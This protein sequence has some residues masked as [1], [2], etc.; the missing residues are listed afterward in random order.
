MAFVLLNPLLAVLL[1]LCIWTV[2]TRKSIFKSTCSS[3]TWLKSSKKNQACEEL[4]RS[5]SCSETRM[6]TPEIEKLGAM[7]PAGGSLPFQLLCIT[8]PKDCTCPCAGNTQSSH[9]EP[10]AKSSSSKYCTQKDLKKNVKLRKCRSGEETRFHFFCL[11]NQS[12]SSWSSCEEYLQTR[13]KSLG[14]R[15]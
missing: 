5:S 3:P 14:M 13:P 15:R 11:N 1:G 12:I 10:F 2:R 9:P 8:V 4:V 7:E 6:H